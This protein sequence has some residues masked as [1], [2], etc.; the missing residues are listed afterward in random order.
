MARRRL[1]LLALMAV[2]TISGCAT[3]E[4][5]KRTET[6]YAAQSQEVFRGAI[7]LPTAKEEK[8]GPS[9]SSC[10]GKGA[11]HWLS[12]ASCLADLRSGRC[13]YYTPGYTGNKGRNPVGERGRVLRPLSQDA[14]VLEDTKYGKR[15][16]A[17]QEGEYFRYESDG[18]VYANNICGNKA[19]KVSYRNTVP[20][21]TKASPTTVDACQALGLSGGNFS[22]KINQNKAE[23]WETV[24]VYLPSVGTTTPVAR[25]PSWR[26]RNRD[27]IITGAKIVGGVAIIGGIGY[28]I[29]SGTCNGF[30]ER[31]ADVAGATT[32][33][34]TEGAVGGWAIGSNGSSGGGGIQ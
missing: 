29:V 4:S 18:I 8:E 33:T 34:T 6:A 15:W 31:G 3:M 12:E 26:E 5:S 13:T 19:Y 30:F 14:C 10:D 20:A 23:C 21:T 24:T 17:H 9:L 22:T 16:V 11:D 32:A 28:C 1:L 27:T 2:I 7:T 25:G